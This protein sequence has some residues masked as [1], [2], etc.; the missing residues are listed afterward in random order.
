VKTLTPCQGQTRPAA[1]SPVTRCVPTPTAD[2]DTSTADI[3]RLKKADH[4]LRSRHAA[5][6]REARATIAAYANHIQAL[7]LRNAEPEAENAA[8]REALHQ[9]G[10]TVA[11]ASSL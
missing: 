1:R 2:G 8:L 9:G 10:G 6:Q 3:A 11:V 7:S 4:T 5:E